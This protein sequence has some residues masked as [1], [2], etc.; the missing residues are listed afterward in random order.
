MLTSCICVFCRYLYISA[1]SHEL[2]TTCPRC[3][4]QLQALSIEDFAKKFEET[5]YSLDLN[6]LLINWQENT[7]L[8]DT[9][10]DSKLTQLIADTSCPKQ[11][12]DKIQKL[13]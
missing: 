5:F 9:D 11:L 10:S 2:P 1:R 13:K 3:S 4:H 8:L 12:L 6:G 7:S